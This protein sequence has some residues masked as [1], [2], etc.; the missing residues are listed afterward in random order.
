MKPSPPKVRFSGFSTN[1]NSTLITVFEGDELMEALSQA[2]KKA[3]RTPFVEPQPERPRSPSPVVDITPAD[4]NTLPADKD[5][6]E[7][8][9]IDVESV[10]TPEEVVEVPPPKPTTRQTRAKTTKDKDEPRLEPAPESQAAPPKRKRGRPRKV[11]IDVGSAPNL[12]NGDT[13]QAP[14]LP[15]KAVLEI[16][17]AKPTRA[18]QVEAQVPS[19]QPLDVEDA[20][21]DV[22]EEIVPPPPARQ[23]RKV[24]QETK[25][26]IAPEPTRKTQPVEKPKPPV[27][28]PKD[29]KPSEPLKAKTQT[30]HNPARRIQQLQTPTA[31]AAPIVLAPAQ[32]PAAQRLR[33][34][35]SIISIES[36]NTETEEDIN[37]KVASQGTLA[38][39]VHRPTTHATIISTPTSIPRRDQHP[40][41]LNAKTSLQPAA[42]IQIKPKPDAFTRLLRTTQPSPKSA[43]A[44]PQK[45]TIPGGGRPSVTFADSLTL[46]RGSSDVSIA[47]DARVK[48]EAEREKL[49]EGASVKTGG[50]MM[51]IVEVLDAIQAVRALR[52]SSCATPIY[53]YC[54]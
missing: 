41:K 38:R 54:L 11:P 51:Q 4:E 37:E 7:D 3:K 26:K 28:E 47:R 27:V 53:N 39:L 16:Q 12:L 9:N 45:R 49:L 32:P 5:T 6:R 15:V 42:G 20:E 52:C 50:V 25:P 29:P 10:D 44:S 21:D 33:A 43:L 22:V 19:A 8:E 17:K 30:D 48:R 34:R 46:R 14:S 36:G 31:K 1:V 40:P 24:A 13:L 18:H 2:A 35:V 23:I